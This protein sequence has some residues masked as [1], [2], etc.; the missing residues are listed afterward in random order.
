MLNAILY[1]STILTTRFYD[2]D[3]IANPAAT[4]TSVVNSTIDFIHYPEG[5]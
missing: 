4:P 3:P 2:E 1:N 5:Y